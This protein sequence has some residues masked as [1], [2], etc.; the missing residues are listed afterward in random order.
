[1]SHNV[2]V[3]AGDAFANVVEKRHSMII[4]KLQEEWSQE[5]LK[6]RQ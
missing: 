2:E 6:H 3:S 4:A 5:S 1:M